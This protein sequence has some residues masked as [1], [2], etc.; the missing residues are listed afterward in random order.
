MITLFKTSMTNQAVESAKNVLV[1]GYVGQGGIV[2]EFEQSL[3][4]VI[5]ANN[6]VTTNSCTS[7]LHLALH[8]L[9]L[10]I[11]SKV[12][13]SPLTCFATNCAIINNLLSPKWVDINDNLSLD[14]NDVLSKLDKE[15]R[16]LM[17]VHW[18]GQPQNLEAISELQKYYEYK[19]K[20]PLY[21]IHDCA[22]AWGA[23]YKSHF[24]GH[25]AEIMPNNFFAYS[26]GPVKPLCCV[27]GG[28]LVCPTEQFT[29]RAKLIR[30][31]GINRN[32]RDDSVDEAGYK[33]HMNDLNASIGLANI[34]QSL[35]WVGKAQENASVLRAYCNPKVKPINSVGDCVSSYYLYTVIVD[36]KERFKEHMNGI[37]IAQPHKRNDKLKCV[38]YLESNLPCLD[39]IAD[40]LVCIPVG[41][42]VDDI[43]A[44]GRLV[45]SYNV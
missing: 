39:S 24:L 31:Y 4:D 1:S 26:F 30:W 37:E 29:S 6:V 27:D 23:T 12:L 33:F 11:G 42:W 45:E 15:T 32:K 20:N 22:H 17:V 9:G 38:S 13:T 44:I 14:M 3:K 34:K 5:L 7:A 8:L 35:N 21:V 16:V 40:K 43:H 25:Y 28:C 18:G 36:D 41:W 19:Y 2:D 10:P